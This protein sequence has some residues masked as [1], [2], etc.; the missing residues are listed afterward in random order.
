MVGL[1]RF[2]LLPILVNR[3]FI[4]AEEGLSWAHF[5]YKTANGEI[6]VYI[7]SILETLFPVGSFI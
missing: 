4:A 7:C 2:D 5:L 3:R 6:N 1:L